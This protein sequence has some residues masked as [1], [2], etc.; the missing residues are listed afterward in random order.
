MD[1][2]MEGAAMLAIDGGFNNVDPSTSNPI[3][4]ESNYNALAVGKI[5]KDSGAIA[6]NIYFVPNQSHGFQSW[7]QTMHHMANKR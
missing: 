5:A 2:E 1:P 6:A 3:Y 4:P 7:N